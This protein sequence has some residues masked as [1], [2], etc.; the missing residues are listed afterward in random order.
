ML[1]SFLLVDHI[2]VDVWDGC[3]AG[4]WRGRRRRKSEVSVV[5]KLTTTFF[6]VTSDVVQLWKR[7]WS[8]SCAFY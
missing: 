5:T 2:C 3:D 4:G 6:S 1:S 7:D 8:W